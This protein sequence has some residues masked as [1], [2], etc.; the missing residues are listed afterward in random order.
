VQH[1]FRFLC[2]ETEDTGSVATAFEL[3]SRPKFSHTP[4]SLATRSFLWGCLAI[5]GNHTG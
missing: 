3:I 4:T 5:R 1:P 2:W